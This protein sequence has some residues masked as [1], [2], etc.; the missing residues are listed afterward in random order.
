MYCNVPVKVS[1]LGQRPANRFDVPKSEIFTTPLYVF[2]STL[3][4]INQGKGRKKVSIKRE[5]KVEIIVSS[6]PNTPNLIKYRKN[7]VHTI[8]IYKETVCTVQ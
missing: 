7:K 1:V 6:G 4:P 3:S 8:R 2:T 5:T